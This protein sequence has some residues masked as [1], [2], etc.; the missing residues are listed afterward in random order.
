MSTD[1][2][3]L[4]TF[5]PENAATYDDRFKALHGIKDMMHLALE[6]AFAQLPSDARILIAGAGTGAEVRHL[7][8]LFPTWHFTLV[9]PAPAMLE[10][11][12]RHAL[13]EGFA[14]RCTF[15]PTYVSDIEADGFDAATSL[16]VSHFVQDAGARTDYFRSIAERLKPGA[17]LFNADLCAD[18]SGPDFQSLMSFWQGMMAKAGMTPEGREQY[19][20]SFGTLFACHGPADVEAMIEAAGFVPPVHCVQAGLIKGWLTAKA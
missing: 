18:P 11:A 3:A 16:L 12:R 9:D 13:A 17:P 14:D 7:A 5:G 8:P 19:A 4:A 2:D 6:S 15:H 20:R 1:F 10:I